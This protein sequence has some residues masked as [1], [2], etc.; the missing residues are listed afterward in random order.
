MLS[1]NSFLTVLNA[2]REWIPNSINTIRR[3]KLKKISMFS[4]LK[5]LGLQKMI[6]ILQ[7][8]IFT[9]A[10]FGYFPKVFLM[11]KRKYN[12]PWDF[13]SFPESMRIKFCQELRI[14]KLFQNKT[15]KA[16]TFKY[17]S[18]RKNSWPIQEIQGIQE[19]VATTRSQTRSFSFQI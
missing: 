15:E 12:V 9:E 11:L 13:P 6:Q 5:W 18:S 14:Q 7:F 2:I 1:E 19:P 10:D 3:R 4:I 16:A 17:I 8:L